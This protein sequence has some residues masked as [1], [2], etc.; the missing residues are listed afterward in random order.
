MMRLKLL[1]FSCIAVLGVVGCAGGK[2]LTVPPTTIQ[3]VETL[4][5]QLNW[6]LSD[7][8]LIPTNTGLMVVSLDNGEVLYRQNEQK[9][10]HPAS[11]MK[12]L[13]TAAALKI[14]GPN[15][16]IPTV[17]YADSASI[18]NSAIIGN[19]YLKGFGNPD[20][21]FEDLR[22]IVS[23]LRKL[24]IRQITGNIVCDDTYFD[25]LY[26]GHGWMW[27]DVSDWYWAPISAL[28]VN[29]NCV[30]I[31]V[32]P[33][34]SIGD[35]LK[36]W[37]SPQT[38]YMNISNTGVTI[39]QE[40]SSMRKRYKAERIWRPI[41]EN[42]FVIEGG[43]AMTDPPRKYAVDVVN[44][45]LFAGTL[46]REILAEQHI[47]FEGHVVSGDTPRN[48][49]VLAQH[50]S[51]PISDIV[52][53]TNKISDN[54]SAEVLLKLIGAKEYGEP[55]TAKKGLRVIKEMLQAVGID[56]T[57]YRIVDGSGVSRYNLITPEIITK[58]LLEMSNDPRVYIDYLA[59]L[60]IAGVDGSLEKR[61][62]NTPASGVLR[63][64]T[65]TLSGISALSGYT[66]TTSGEKLVF[67]MIMG[68]FVGSAS[69]IRKIQDEIGALLSAFNRNYMRKGSVR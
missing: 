55:G 35:P 59:S 33:G 60:P 41:A 1:L 51:P 21:H 64:K 15:Y 6:I 9:L 39:A 18:R 45:A 11:N 49:T 53:N 48:A 22:Q 50:L 7:S 19:L 54:L 2:K 31:T 46:L 68:H 62:Q 16:R 44:A 20:L 67:S 14:L 57:S 4:K 38:S 42:T 65:G 5:I 27:D 34:D 26:W 28:S 32:S 10:I 12:L 63:A 37:M 47:S 52:K 56:S 66:I 30:E 23:E 61:M 69:G 8:L 43:L 58:L 13:T 17:L 24:G 25:D 3:T 29:D 40:D 36:V